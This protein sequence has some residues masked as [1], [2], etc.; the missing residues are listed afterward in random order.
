MC[1]PE[2]GSVGVCMW[3]THARCTM[4]TVHVLG[5][6]FS[7]AAAEIEVVSSD[8]ISIAH[9]LLSHANS[10]DEEIILLN[11]NRYAYYIFDYV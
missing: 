4:C 3:P 8:P 2:C 10:I 5:R 9:L 1:S 6:E 11:Y 7:A